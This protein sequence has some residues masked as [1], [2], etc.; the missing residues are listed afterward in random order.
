MIHL[1]GSASLD[2]KSNR[3]IAVRT[4]TYFLITSFFNTILGVILA[5]AIHPGSAAQKQDRT[6]VDPGKHLHGPQN[7]LLD[8]MFDLGRNI[9]PANILT[10]LFESV[11]EVQTVYVQIF[12]LN[13]N[14]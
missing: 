4:F 3:M 7:T 2:I 12:R 11:Y 14:I 10:P 13:V 5:V 6:L 1:I 9:V 8:N